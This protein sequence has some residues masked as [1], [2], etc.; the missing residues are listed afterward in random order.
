MIRL[1]PRSTRT[2]TLFPYTTLFGSPVVERPRCRSD[3]IHHATQGMGRPFFCHPEMWEGD[4]AGTTRSLTPRAQSMRLP[5][6]DAAV[7]H[8]LTVPG[9]IGMYSSSRQSA[10][11]VGGQPSRDLL[12]LR[13]QQDRKNTRL[14]YSH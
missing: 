2:Y 11:I 10:L 14:N 1:P 8:A 12:I 7:T 9:T 13:V 4:R 6:M 5:L 3:R